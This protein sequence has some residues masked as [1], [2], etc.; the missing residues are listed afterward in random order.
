MQMN[1]KRLL[2]W[3]CLATSAQLAF[4]QTSDAGGNLSGKVIETM[5]TAGYTYVKVDTGSQK[6]WAVTTRYAASQLS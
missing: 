2:W 1:M 6:I 4:A 3:L 5:T